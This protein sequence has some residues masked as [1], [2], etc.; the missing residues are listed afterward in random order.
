[1]PLRQRLL[2]VVVGLLCWH[3][4]LPAHAAGESLDAE[5]QRAAARLLG[6]A[7]V[8]GQKVG[9]GHFPM[10]DGRLTE[11]GVHLAEQLDVALIQRA[12]PS[13]FEVVNRSDLCQVIR[14]NGFWI[15]DQFDPAL[16]Q[17]LGRLAGLDLLATGRIADEGSHVRVTVR[18]V[19]AES[20]KAIWANTFRVP[21]DPG[22]RSLLNRGVVS[23]GCGETPTSTA[24]SVPPA[25]PDSLRV[26][27]W[28]D[29]T[30]YG[31]GD[32]VRFHL[33]SNRDAYVT[34]VDIGTSGKV[35]ILFPNRLHPSHFVRG[36]Q[37]VTIPLVDAGFD[38]VI[39]GP[40]GF[41]QVRV[42]ATDEPLTFHPD[43]FPGQQGMFRSL[44]RNE[45]LGLTRDIKLKKAKVPPSRQAEE[46]LILR[47]R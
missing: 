25:A 1:M 36:G 27:V 6:V 33:R 43:D 9:L 30:E 35:T 12:G 2:G 28:A 24:P 42:I 4:F 26:N 31:I 22:L 38:L 46:V 21:L 8:K 19:S 45:S 29:R 11:F 3:L 41:E 37:T 18:F 32:T 34:L 10:L 15:N 13:G 23:G 16:P 44:D 40:P 47:I 7:G 17:K 14:E 39:H 5:I 20:G